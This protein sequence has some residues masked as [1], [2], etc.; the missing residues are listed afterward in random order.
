[1]MTISIIIYLLDI[2]HLI[3]NQ[4]TQ[5]ACIL[6]DLKMVVFQVQ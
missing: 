3:G 4:E 2:L 5:I 1:M 6:H